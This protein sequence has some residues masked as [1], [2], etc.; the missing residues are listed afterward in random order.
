MQYIIED[1][2]LIGIADAI[3]EKTGETSEIPLP[4]MASKI[5]GIAVT[6]SDGTTC[7]EGVLF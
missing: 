5:R 1:T 2:A 6:T 3:R 7:A 4:S